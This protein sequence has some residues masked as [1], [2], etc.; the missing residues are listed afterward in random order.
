MLAIDCDAVDKLSLVVDEQALGVVAIIH[1]ILLL[2]LL[3]V[4]NDNFTPERLPTLAQTKRQRVVNIRNKLATVISFNLGQEMI[5]VVVRVFKDSSQAWIVEVFDYFDFFNCLDYFFLLL[6]LLLGGS[7]FWFAR[8]RLF[9]CLRLNR[10]FQRVSVIDT[11]RSDHTCE[12][13]CSSSCKHSSIIH[14]NLNDD[15]WL[16][17]RRIN[18]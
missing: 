6:L 8:A 5:G 11:S 7:R 2:A 3:V 4:V 10:S 17:L 9:S 12:Q 15:L 18:Y 1:V 16:K 14:L 13:K